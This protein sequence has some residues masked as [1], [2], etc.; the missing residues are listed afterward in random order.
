MKKKLSRRNFLKKSTIA[1]TG[2]AIVPSIL[3]SGQAWGAKKDKP[4]MFCYQ[5][6]Q[7]MRGK[8]CTKIGVCGK[9]PDV[10]ALQDL[11]IHTLKGLSIAA[12]AGRKVNIS[13][14]KINRFTCMALF[15]T[16]TNVEFDPY[17][18]EDLLSESVELRDSMIARVKS[19]GGSIDSTSDALTLKL[20]PS[21]EGLVKQG[22]SYGLMSEPD[23]N[24]DIRSLQHL[25]L[26]GLKGM[27]AYTD[28]AAEHDQEDEGNYEF[29]HR[30]LAAMTDKTK[31]LKS[32]LALVLECGEKNLKAMELLDAGNTG[33]YGHP[34]P[35]AVPLGSKKGKAILVSG[36]D[37]IDLERVLEASKD[38][39]IVVYTHGEMLPCHGYPVLKQ[40]FP[41]FYGHYGTAW[42]NQK[43]EFDKFPGAI[44]M[45]SNCI[46]KPRKSYKKN[47]FTTGTVGWP[48][49]AHISKSNLKPLID[50]ALELPGYT[51]DTENGKVLVGF[52]HKAVLSVAD[53]IVAGVKDKS[54]RHFFLVG[55]C[56]G[57]K[58]S[59]NYYTEFVEKTPKDSIVLTL[60]C[61]KFKFF[62]K[63]LG[64]INGIPRLLD[65]GQC[66]DAHSAVQ[67]AVALTKAFNTDVNGLPLSFIISWY[68]QKA[69][70]V[71]LSLL[72][73]GIKDIRLGPSLPAFITPNVLDVLVKNYN[74]MP[75]STPDKDL[76]A[77]L[78]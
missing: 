9:T 6:E 40:R 48:G 28:H 52:G 43:K 2:T 74:L 17:R 32:L 22:G 44:L 36:H 62:T 37:L 53:K 75:I 30:G 51:K 63:Q 77:I 72:A 54:I 67:I 33:A 25:L 12:V 20:K 26:F 78:G 45:T 21:L 42:Q 61:G 58:K 1:I 11:L 70:A 64:E 10:A 55:G 31:D 34:V 14:Q 49:V 15:S 19:A 38:K 7:T 39:G 23:I 68:E 4:A 71:L 59:R 18:F 47:I 73:L 65:V 29:I 76:E 46:Q 57:V 41:H 69:V 5:C 66:N 60:A 50:K 8:G 24:P 16:L 56:D 13:D 35:T 3:S 27:G